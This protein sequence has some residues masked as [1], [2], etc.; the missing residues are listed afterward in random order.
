MKV[1]A[2][3]LPRELL[4]SGRYT[5]G[6][7]AL[8]GGPRGSV[9]KLAAQGKMQAAARTVGTLLSAF[10][11]GNFFLEVTAC[12]ERERQ[13]LPL[14]STLAFDVGVPLVFIPDRY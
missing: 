13:L 4:L 8:S 1:G 3:K 11:D 5:C 2:P 6:L 14:L 12:S 7:V 10:G 9:Y